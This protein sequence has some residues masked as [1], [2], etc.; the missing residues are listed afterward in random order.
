LHAGEYPA[1]N[2]KVRY[3]SSLHTPAGQPKLPDWGQQIDRTKRLVLVTQDTVADCD[4]GRVI[5]STLVALGG[6]KCHDHRH[7]RRPASRGIPVANLIITNGGYGTVNM[8]ISHGIPII[9]DGLTKEVAA[10][11]PWSTT[12]IDLRSNQATSVAIP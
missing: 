10:H 4:P 9:S 6:R 12:G 3:I 5:V 7:Q 1:S 11:V 8:A 2:S